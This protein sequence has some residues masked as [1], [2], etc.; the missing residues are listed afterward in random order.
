MLRGLVPVLG[1]TGPDGEAFTRA[2][3]DVL[4]RLTRLVSSRAPGTGY[5]LT[6]LVDASNQHDLVV[7]VEPRLTVIKRRARAPSE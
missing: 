1:D 7:H 6:I 2:W 5:R 4:P 3:F